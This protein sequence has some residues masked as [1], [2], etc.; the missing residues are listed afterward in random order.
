MLATWYCSINL[1]NPVYFILEENHITHG[2]KAPRGLYTRPPASIVASA[3]VKQARV[4]GVTDW[5]SYSLEVT[6]PLRVDP[7]EWAPF[8][9]LRL[10]KKKKKKT[11][12]VLFEVFCTPVSPPWG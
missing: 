7:W 3:E 4:F 2:V 6:L 10:F 9:L 1:V 11:L 5:L 12:L 8:P